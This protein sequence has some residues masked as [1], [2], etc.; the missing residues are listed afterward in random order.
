MINQ[1][2]FHYKTVIM[3]KSLFTILVASLLVV[4]LSFAQN[5]G[6]KNGL[7]YNLTIFDHYSP[8]IEDLFNPDG[9]TTVGAKIAYHRNLGGPLN[10]EIPARL[11]ITE[12]PML[13]ANGDIV[14]GN[15]LMSGGLEALLQLQ[16]GKAGSLLHPYLSAG[17]GAIGVEGQGL[18]IQVPLGVGLDLRIFDNFYL[19][20]RSEYRLGFKDYTDI[21]GTQN[22]LAHNFGVKALFGKGDATPK[23]KKDPD[24]DGD[25]ITDLNDQCPNVIGTAAMNGC[26]DSDN[27]GIADKDDSCPKVAGIAAMNGCPDADGDGLADNDDKCPNEAGP[28]D[29]DGCPIAD[30]DGDG[31]V[32][33]D[34]KCPNE[35]GPR[36]NDGC[37]V[38]DADGDGI[39][40][41]EDDCPNEAGKASL[42]G[43]PDS[44]NDGV[45]DKNDNCPTEA[46]KPALK[47]CPDSDNDG[48]PNASDRCPSVAGPTNNNGCPV[49]EIKEEDK[50]V[51]E[52]AAQNIQFESNSSYF[53]AGS[54]EKVDEIARILKEY[55]GYNVTIE[56]HTD[57][58][59]DANYNQMLS[60]KRA[61]RCYDRLVELGISPSRVRHAGYGESRP[62][63]ENNTAA[64]RKKNRRV[65]FDLF[66]R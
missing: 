29:N 59:G 35:A 44:D 14:N 52:F 7:S 65:T 28:K 49:K 43:C 5:E 60:E 4:Q 8:A 40:D 22:H 11:G 62:I 41:A 36:S 33:A 55:P 2:K 9:N 48:V 12:L 38:A 25:G 66:R 47:G 18:G 37:P 3:R 64:G 57:S 39:A 61:K 58:A 32:D 50:R 16:L 26:P 45:A 30:A 51:L 23:P 34:D 24:T 21:D 1:L 13:A 63:A 10:L 6:Q 42:N 53:K 15:R 27:D 46:G 31:V 19:Q 20:G 56:G 54:Q 17:L